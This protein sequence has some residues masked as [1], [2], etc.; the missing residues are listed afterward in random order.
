MPATFYGGKMEKAYEIHQ[1]KL[2]VDHAEDGLRATAAKRLKVGEPEIQRLEIRRRSIDARHGQISFTYSVVA[3]VKEGTKVSRDAMEYQEHEQIAIVPGEQ[4]LLYRPIVVGAG[5]CGLF[6]ALELS[7]MGYA[8]I[9]LERGMPVET[10][11]SQVDAFF[12]GGVHDEE[13]NVLFGEGG[14][15]AFSDGKLTTRIKDARIS[16]VIQTFLDCGAPEEIAYLAKPHIGTDLLT[17]ILKNIRKRILALGGEVQFGARLCAIQMGREGK[18]STIAYAH[19]GQRCELPAQAVVLCCGHSARDTYEMLERSGVAMEFKP[20]AIGMR[21]EH[22]QAD[23]D[24]AQYGRLAG[25]PR[26]PSAEYSLTTKVQDRGVYTFC[27]CPGGTVIPSI[28]EGG[29]FCVNGMSLHGRK[30]RN[31]NAAVVAQV[32]QRDMPSGDVLA[33][34]AFQRQWEQKAF[35]LSGSYA[36]PVQRLGDFLSSQTSKGFGKVQPSYPRE[37]LL[38]DM[39]SILPDFVSEA[40]GAAFADFGHKIRG[41]DHP[42]AVL[43]GIETRTSAPVRIVRGEDLQS[44]S[45][46]GLYP[47]GEGAGYAGGIMSAAVDGI[48]VAQQII[49][50]YKKPL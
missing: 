35:A 36:A 17:G 13:S 23:I 5:P 18:L 29:M 33:G 44:I 45:C 14:A 50:R 16:K 46:P 37:Q 11:T 15:G 3:Y 10:R 32:L 8:P 19:Q 49:Q 4:P 25:H 27:M 31:A 43:T 34:V 2:D 9:L 26:L 47:A 1:I 42:D 12:R 30:G 38:Y 7:K 48:R 24:S 6:C 28:S 40:I 41:Y 20:F 22:L 21:I 39:R